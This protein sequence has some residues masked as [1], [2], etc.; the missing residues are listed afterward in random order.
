MLQNRRASE[1]FIKPALPTPMLGL[2]TSAPNVLTESTGAGPTVVGGLF[3]SS[4]NTPG[5]SASFLNSLGNERLSIN[6]TSLLGYSAAPPV[7]PPNNS[8]VQTNPLSFH[9]QNTSNSNMNTSGTNSAF[10]PTNSSGGAANTFAQPASPMDT[11][12]CKD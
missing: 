3:S 10:T 2:N 6:S 9:L 12:T 4:S 1:R 5:P 8:S 11:S 7:L